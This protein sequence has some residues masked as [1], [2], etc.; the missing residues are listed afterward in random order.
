MHKS[1]RGTAIAEIRITG[2]ETAAGLRL[3]VEREYIYDH[4]PGTPRM[5]LKPAEI[6]IALG[7]PDEWGPAWEWLFDILAVI[8]QADTRAVAVVLDRPAGEAGVLCEALTRTVA[9][10]FAW[11][12]Q[13]AGEGQ[14]L[15]LPGVAEE[16][17]GA[18]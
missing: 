1:N 11:T 13:P 18:G 4:T 16:A 10:E 3:R 6:G 9:W 14:Q 15:V 7:Q 2:T 12:V 8:A 17:K 5:A